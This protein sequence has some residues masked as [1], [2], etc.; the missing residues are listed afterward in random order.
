MERP[1]VV[2]QGNVTRCHVRQESTG[3]TMTNFLLTTG[4]HWQ[5][6]L[7][8]L[9]LAT[10]A[11]TLLTTGLHWQ[12]SLQGLVLATHAATLCQLG[13]L[14]GSSEC[15]KGHSTGDGLPTVDD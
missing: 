10:H 5:C 8:G 6:S 1:T 7:Q 13:C 3:L 14:R 11:A 4:L 2:V 9:V 12:C 15:L